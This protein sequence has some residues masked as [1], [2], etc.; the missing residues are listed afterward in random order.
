MS[1]ESKIIYFPNLN[2]LRFVAAFLVLLNHIEWVKQTEGITNLSNF[3]F[4]S[5][6]GSLGV[7]LFFVLSGFLITYLLLLEKKET[8]DINIKH[9]YIRRILRIWPLYYLTVI[10][11]FFVLP[12]LVSIKGYE[13]SLFDSAY[14]AKLGLFTF[15]MANVSYTIFPIVPFA[16]Q[17]WSV[18]VE[19]QFYL[20]WPLL[21]KK[22]GKYICHV[23]IFVVVFVVGI[24]HFFNSATETQP[25]SSTLLHWAFFIEH[26]RIQCMAIGGIGAYLLIR[27]KQEILTFL[28]GKILQIVVLVAAVLGVCT[29]LSFGKLNEEIMS[30][31]FGLIILNAASNQQNI[32]RLENRLFLFLGKISYGLYVYQILAIKISMIIVTNYMAFSSTLKTNIVYYIMSILFTVVMAAA[33]YF[34][35]EARFLSLKHK[36]STVLSNR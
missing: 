6:G 23:L 31:L 2:G 29:S 19:E 3:S 8:G 22:A 27:Q 5:K 18:G 34:L 1:Q 20:F 14:F 10:L 24:K 7:S 17:L 30:V 28:Y 16:S 15:L 36:F 25:N 26:F 32:F 9:F 11:A 13:L 33:S 12:N 35:F 21:N 4:F